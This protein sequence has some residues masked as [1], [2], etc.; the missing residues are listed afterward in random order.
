MN[1]PPSEG[2][3]YRLLDLIGRGGFGN[4][5]RARLEGPAGFVKEVAIKIVRSE[6]VAAE[7]V[8]RFRDEARILGLVRDRTIVGVDPPI[9][10]GGKLALVMEYIDG[11]SCQRIM[12]F[13]PIPPRPALEI[14]GEI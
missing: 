12:Q 4:V 3:R 2:R 11:A 8:A 13:A 14:V 7:E 9:R 5:Y 6:D 10:L 1:A